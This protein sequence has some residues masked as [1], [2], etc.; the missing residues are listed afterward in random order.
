MSELPW[1]AELVIEQQL[2]PEADVRAAAAEAAGGTPLGDELVERE[3]LHPLQLQALR[4]AM[5]DLLANQA[6][7]LAV[8]CRDEYMQG[9]LLQTWE[10]CSAAQVR[11]AYEERLMLLAEGVEGQTLGELLVEH[12]FLTPFQ[13]RDLASKR[14][15]MMRCPNDDTVYDVLGYEEGFRLRCPACK[16]PLERVKEGE[17]TK[18]REAKQI[19]FDPKS[20][21]ALVAFGRLALKQKLLTKPQLAKAVEL[22]AKT[23]AK[24]ISKC[25]QELGFLTA[26]QVK[27]IDREVKKV[28]ASKKDVKDGGMRQFSIGAI[29]LQLGYYDENTLEVL[30]EDQRKLAREGHRRRIGELMVE[31][32]FLTTFQLTRLLALQAKTLVVCPKDGSQFNVQNLPEGQDLKCPQC[33]TPLEVPDKVET[34]EAL[35][36]MSVNLQDMV[37]IDAT[38]TPKRD[39]RSAMPEIGTAKEV[40]GRALE[41]AKEAQATETPPAKA[42]APAGVD[43][44]QLDMT[45]S[46]HDY[47]AA[48]DGPELRKKLDPRELDAW[49]RRCLKKVKAW[50]VTTT[51]G[52]WF[53]PFCGVAISPRKGDKDYVPAIMEHLLRDCQVFSRIG[54]PP[55]FPLEELKRRATYLFVKS[56]LARDP[57]W[58]IKDSQ[59]RWV[60][61]FTC[62][63]TDIDLSAGRITRQAADQITAH[64]AALPGFDPRKPPATRP[65]KEIIEKVARAFARNRLARKVATLVKQQPA[66]QVIENERWVCPYTAK[67]VETIVVASPFALQHNAPPQIASYLL[68]E[69]P[70]FKA[71]AKPE[72]SAERLRARLAGEETPEPAPQAPTID[73]GGAKVDEEISETQRE[74]QHQL[75]VHAAELDRAAVKATAMLPELP[76]LPGFEVFVHYQPL[77]GIGGDFYDFIALHEG[78]LGVAIGDVSGHGVDAAMVMTMAK[79]TLKIVA[80]ASSSPKAALMLANEE[81]LQDL[82]GRTF[83]T[84]WYGMLDPRSW[85]LRYARAGHE[86]LLLFNPNRAPAMQELLTEGMTAGITSGTRYEK[87]MTEGEL[88][89]QQGDLL[90]LYTDGISEVMNNA[91]EQ[92]GRER[93]EAV[94]QQSAGRSCKEVVDEIKAALDGF[95]DGEVDDDQTIM[96][97]RYT[98]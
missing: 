56:R 6:H 28:L 68:N 5:R 35:Q 7:P 43:A 41:Q 9:Q 16:G 18:A 24:P 73:L 36:T 93:I 53:C 88:K 45:I 54:Q 17:D 44:D 3:V 8:R 89:L 47:A 98:G 67:P 76:D 31:S 81:L 70:P 13:L 22:Q 86:P 62:K 91:Q 32:G 48:S 14:K 27:A 90:L 95:R 65:H 42:A 37:A 61:P 69:C 75:D 87:V 20:A 78:N 40:V 59:K 82:D 30:L 97:M 38:R 92:F 50:Q 49:V 2:A 23:P 51:A 64:V 21:G 60:C 80:R 26:T 84:L 12:G 52:F 25:A 85:T 57:A 96:V 55:T 39:M 79:K 34:V 63:V 19:F 83:V 4:Q 72:M 1:I 15:V 46:L 71:G 58:H 74:L 29:G 66:W 10:L 11:Q 77:E 94:M 33:G